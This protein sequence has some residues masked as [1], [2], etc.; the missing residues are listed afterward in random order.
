VLT[1]EVFE[2]QGG[3]LVLTSVTGDVKRWIAVLSW[4][5]EKVLR[6]RGEKG[7]ST[8]WK[9]G[10]DTDTAVHVMLQRNMH[11]FLCGLPGGAHALLLI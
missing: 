7:V 2:R 10:G 3:P 6:E 9:K 8:W 11:S 4:A 1:V 5:S